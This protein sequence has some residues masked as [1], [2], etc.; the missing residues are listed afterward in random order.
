M[1]LVTEHSKQFLRG[2]STQDMELKI[3]F[4]ILPLT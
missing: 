3:G 4:E 1:S 2:F